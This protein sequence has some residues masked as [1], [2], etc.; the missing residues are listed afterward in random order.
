MA[1]F[2]I[3]L[4]IVFLLIFV[5]VFSVTVTANLTDWLLKVLP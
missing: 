4:G 1:R 3:G 2:F 5:W